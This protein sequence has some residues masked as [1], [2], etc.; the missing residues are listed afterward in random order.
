MDNE[1]AQIAILTY[2]NRY[3]NLFRKISFSAERDRKIKVLSFGCSIGDE[4]A[5]IRVAL[6]NADIYACD[7]NVVALAAAQ[8][9]MGHL[10]TIF[11]ASAAEIAAHGPYDIVLALS[12]LCIS[13]PPKDFATKFPFGKFND[14]TAMLDSFVVDG[15]ILAI[16][17][18][19]YL[20]SASTIARKYSVIRDNTYVLWGGTAIFCRDGSP[21][22]RVRSTTSRFLTLVCDTSE[23]FDEWHICDDLFIKD[24][25]GDGTTMRIEQIDV[26]VRQF[27]GLELVCE[28][29]R[30]NFDGLDPSVTKG[31]LE[32]RNEFKWMRNPLNEELVLFNNLKR[33]RLFSEGFIEARDK[34]GGADGC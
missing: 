26:P 11:Y 33:S 18:S 34:F 15:G 23:L 12:V 13:P 1:Q 20:F 4:I 19:S 5:M 7:I 10:A 16:K 28:W 22:S 2:A 9:T 3:R 21:M 14:M 24:G 17:N 25:G 32:V 30:S 29:N 31:C 27:D 8:E 6:P